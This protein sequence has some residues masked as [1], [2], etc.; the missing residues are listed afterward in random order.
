MSK[1]LP[2]IH[3][4]IIQQI[5]SQGTMALHLPEYEKSLKLLCD[6]LGDSHIPNQATSYV[7]NKLGTLYTFFKEK[8]QNNSIH[9]I[10]MEV[11]VKIETRKKT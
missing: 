6:I 2:S 3:E 10:I 5:E 4:V 9:E 11:I 8:P 1:K 7:L